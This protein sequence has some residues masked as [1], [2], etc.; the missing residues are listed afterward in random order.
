MKLI[1]WNID[2]LNAALTSDSARAVMSRAVIDTLITE[3]ADIIAIQETK[4]SAKGPTKKHLQILQ[5]YFP[6]YEVS[7]RSS[8]E[9][10]RKGYAG[11]MFLYKSSLT[12]SISYPEIGA[13]DTMDSEGRIITLEF[14]K[15][16]VTQ[17]YTPNAGDGLKRLA[18]RQIWDEKY[19]D[20]LAELDQV[21]PVLATG[22]YN[23]AHKEID[24]AH[25]SSNRRSPGF[26]DEERAGFTNLLAKGFTDTFR[27]IHGDIP[28]VYS[29][30]AQRSKTSKINNSGW[31]IDYWLTSSRIADKITKS[32]MIDSGARQDHTPIVLE[33]DL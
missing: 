8:V 30:W 4:L 33:I 31:R 22:D 19:A 24:L 10:A 16:F 28:D 14:D 7:W 15:F 20:Y 21:K 26:T 17:V 12:P 5:D 32:E 6:E 29:W 11:T 23:V 13:P 25:P 1:S 2:S 3:N 27:Y 9:P 18:E